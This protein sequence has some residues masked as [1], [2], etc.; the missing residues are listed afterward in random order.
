MEDDA[1]VG[2]VIVK[3]L[4]HLGFEPHWVPSGNH[5]VDAYREGMQTGDPFETVLLD[6][7]IAE[8][9]GGVE[10]LQCLREIDP[11]VR[12]VLAS[13]SLEDLILPAVRER[14]FLAALSKPFLMSE[15]SA[16]LREAAL[17]ETS[18]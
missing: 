11:E 1:E 10:T 5:A 18:R 8:G 15:L 13:G 16:V 14:G 17:K 6:L 7:F 4:S 9:M 12:A 2:E 3:M